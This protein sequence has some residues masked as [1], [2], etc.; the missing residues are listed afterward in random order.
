MT[1]KRAP[2][3]ALARW[4]AQQLAEARAAEPYH[5][6][7]PRT[8]NSDFEAVSARL[9][10]MRE[11]RDAAARAERLSRA[12][13]PGRD[14][15]PGETVETLAH[16]ANEKVR[17]VWVCDQIECLFQRRFAAARAGAALEVQYERYRIARSLEA[18]WLAVMQVRT[19]VRFHRVRPD[20]EEFALMP[21]GIGA[22]AP[23]P[24]LDEAR[25]ALKRAAAA[26]E[27]DL[28]WHVLFDLVVDGRGLRDIERRRR[29]RHATAAGIIDEALD[30]ISA[31]RVYETRKWRV[32]VKGAV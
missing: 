30:A 18:D 13:G 16:D 31:A 17:R 28:A 21:A 5:A 26:V 14:G 8:V 23:Q 25:Q 6:P 7:R 1:K 2:N 4:Q 12:Q 19:P 32:Q 20:A 10:P 22:G 24:R 27:T 29:L 15:D 9:E 3:Q 11:K